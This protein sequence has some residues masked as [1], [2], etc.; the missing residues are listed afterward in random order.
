[1]HPLL[2]PWRH[3]EDSKRQRIILHK[4]IISF[5]YTPKLSLE[6]EKVYNE[7]LTIRENNKV[8]IQNKDNTKQ[9]MTVI[10]P[11]LPA[12]ACT[13]T[14]TGPGCPSGQ[15]D[16]AGSLQ[17]ASSSMLRT[18]MASTGVGM[19]Y[20]YPSQGY[21]RRNQL[22]RNLKNKHNHHLVGDGCP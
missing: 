6:L 9:I 19:A 15:Q 20:V 21:G 12:S 8:Q 17:S 22:Y 3:S 10:S 7:M 4:C 13:H 5:T 11:S 2:A 14:Q 1:M 18:W 16:E